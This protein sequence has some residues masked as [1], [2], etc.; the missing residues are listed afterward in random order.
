[1]RSL[2]QIA[3]RSVLLSFNQSYLRWFLLPSALK[4]G[5]SPTG[6]GEN[7]SITYTSMK[8]GRYKHSKTGNMYRVIGIALHSETL[9]EMVVYE[10][11]Y[12]NPRGKLWVRPKKMFLEDVIL[13]GKSVPRFQFEGE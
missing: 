4:R 8:L 11:L 2:I 9:E 3:T 6:V 1:M 13:K 5:R 12:D 10:C 7:K